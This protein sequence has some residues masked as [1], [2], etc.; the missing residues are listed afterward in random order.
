MLWARFHPKTLISF[1]LLQVLGT[2]WKIQACYHCWKLEKMP[3]VTK[4]NH[5][6][7]IEQDNDCC[8]EKMKPWRALARRWTVC[9]VCDVCFVCFV[10]FFLCFFLV[11]SVWFVLF[12]F[13]CFVLFFLVLLVWWRGLFVVGSWVTLSVLGLT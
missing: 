1:N 7:E 2:D 4:P 12:C 13:V 9:F 10:L 5:W 8:A 11:S 6:C 3:W